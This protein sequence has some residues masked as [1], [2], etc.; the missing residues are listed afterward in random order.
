MASREEIKE[1]SQRINEIR[2]VAK[3][4]NVVEWPWRN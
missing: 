4:Y 1:A 3:K 2:N